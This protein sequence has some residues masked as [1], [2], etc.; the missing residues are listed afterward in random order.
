MKTWVRVTLL[1]VWALIGFFVLLDNMNYAVS[2]GQNQVTTAQA[3][4]FL[5]VVSLWQLV[6]LG[7]LVALIV[8][9]IRRTP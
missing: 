7:A 8:D 9:L 1:V 6:G 3:E 2:I 5:L 4:S